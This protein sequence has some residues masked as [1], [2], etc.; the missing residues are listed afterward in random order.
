MIDEDDVDFERLPHRRREIVHCLISLLPLY[1]SRLCSYYRF[2][3]G[4]YTTPLINIRLP[5]F[6]IDAG[7]ATV[8]I[9]ISFR[10]MFNVGPWDSPHHTLSA[11][12]T[13][14]GVTRVLLRLSHVDLPG[15]KRDQCLHAYVHGAVVEKQFP[16]L[17]H[18]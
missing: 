9:L 12:D 5:A 8:T 6:Q 3:D 4:G 18:N 11:P 1:T 7:A 17:S 16:I 13:P 15:A 14:P 10:S 2:Y